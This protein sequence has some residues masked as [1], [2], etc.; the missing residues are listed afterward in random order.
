MCSCSNSV[1]TVTPGTSFS[2]NYLLLIQFGNFLNPPNVNNQPIAITV[3]INSTHY[4]EVNATIS[5]QLYLSNSLTINSFVQSDFSVGTTN[6]TYA[7][8][9]SVGDY[10]PQDPVL[11]ILLPSEIGFGYSSYSCNFFGTAQTSVPYLMNSGSQKVLT[12]YFRSASLTGAANRTALLTVTG[13]VNPMFI[14]NSSTFAII[15]KDV[16]ASN[17]AIVGCTVSELKTSLSA[18]SNTSGD[19]PVY[20]MLMNTTEVNQPALTSVK[21]MLYAPIPMG[22][23]V[24]ILLPPK[25]QP[26]LPVVC[27]PISGYK[28]TDTNPPTCT[29]N[30][31]SNSI[32][33]VNF[34]YQDLVT[35]STA[36]MS[37]GIINPPDS[38]VYRFDFQTLDEIGRIIGSSRRGFNYSAEPGTLTVSALRNDTT[39]DA[40]LKLSFNV[41]FENNLT[42]GSRLQVVI[43][44]EMANITGPASVTCITTGLVS[45]NCTNMPFTGADNT[46]FFN[47]SFTPV[48]S[49][50]CSAGNFIAFSIT[51]LRNPSYIN[52]GAW[53]ININSVSQFFNG[54]IDNNQI[55]INT[56]SLTTANSQVTNVSIG[57]SYVAGT[58]MTL[59]LTFSISLY[60]QTYDGVIV[61]YFPVNASFVSLNTGVLAVSVVN[62]GTTTP[63]TS[64]YQYYDNN[65]MAISSITISG[66]CLK[67]AC[68]S[69]LTVQIQGITF[70]YSTKSY[71]PY[72][73]TIS[74][75]NGAP[76]S[77]GSI[78]Y[79][80]T[81]PTTRPSALTIGCSSNVTGSLSNYNFSFV[82]SI[83]IDSQPNGGWMTISLPTDLDVSSSNGCNVI[84]NV[85]LG[86]SM[87]CTLQNRT[88]TIGYVTGTPQA[89][90]GTMV[91]LLI[92]N[93][94]NP[95]YTMPLA[96]KV[97][98]YFNGAP[99]EVFSGSVSM[100]GLAV[101]ISS[102]AKTNNTY[103]TSSILSI[104]PTF[105]FPVLSSDSVSLHIHQSLFAFTKNFVTLT[106][107]STLAS[108]LASAVVVLNATHQIV[109]FSPL[110]NSSTLNISLQI[111]NPTTTQDLPE[112]W[113]V[114][115]R[116]NFSSQQAT[117]KLLPCDPMVLGGSV[118]SSARVTGDKTNLTIAFSQNVNSVTARI[119]VPANGFDYS[120]ALLP[121][122]SS[123][124]NN[125]VVALTSSPT[126]IVIRN[127][128]NKADVSTVNASVIIY[129]LDINAYPVEVL[130]VSAST[131][132]ANTPKTVSMSGVRSIVDSA[133]PTNL[134]LNITNYNIQT[135]LST[136]RIDLPA[137][138][139]W[140][141]A[142]VTCSFVVANSDPSLQNPCQVTGVAGTSIT[143][144]HPCSASK[145]A[146][147]TFQLV[148]SGTGNLYADSSLTNVTFL[149]NGSASEASTLLVTPPVTTP[150]LTNASIAL[151]SNTITQNNTVSI[152]FSCPLSIPLNSTV[153][154]QFDDL[155]FLA[156]GD[157]KYS[158]GTTNYTGCSNTQGAAGYVLTSR[159]NTL[160]MSSIPANTSIQIQLP[161]TNSYAAYNISQSRVSVVVN[162]SNFTIGVFTQSMRTLLNAD[163]FM[164]TALKNV[165]LGRNTTA[166][167]QSAT[168]SLSLTI[169]VNFYMASILTLMIPKDEVSIPA[170]SNLTVTN[171]TITYSSED[172]SYYYYSLKQN[173]C[174]SN[175]C[176]SRSLSFSIDGLVNNNYPRFQPNA[177]MVGLV[178]NNTLVAP[179]Q[180]LSTT[181]LRASQASITA[182]RS[183]ADSL[184]ITNITINLG[185]IE[186]IGSAVTVLVSTNQSIFYG[187]VSNAWIAGT[188]SNTVVSYINQVNGSYLNNVSIS[189][190]SLQQS[191]ALVLQ[192]TNSALSPISG[193]NF[194][195]SIFNSSLLFYTNSLVP[196]TNEIVPYA[197]NITLT[198]SVSTVASLYSLSIAGS[199]DVADLSGYSLAIGTVEGT[200]GNCVVGSASTS[201]LLNSSSFSLTLTNL[202]N[203]Q[204]TVDYSLSMRIASSNYVFF[205]SPVPILP[206]L[207]PISF[208]SQVSLSN[209][210]VY[211]TVN[212][213]VSLQSVSGSEVNVTFPSTLFTTLSNCYL[214]S[215]RIPNC[216][217]TL[218]NNTYLVRARAIN[219][220]AST[221]STLNFEVQLCPT[222]TTIN[223][224]VPISVRLPYSV[225]TSQ[226]AVTLIPETLPLS[227]SSSSYTINAISTISVSFSVLGLLSTYTEIRLP[228]NIT[229]QYSVPNC[230]HTQVNDTSIRIVVFNTTNLT[231]VVSNVTNPADNRPMTVRINQISNSTGTLVGV[232][233]GSYRMTELGTITV[234]EALRNSS[235]L[236]AP[237][238]VSMAFRFDNTGTVLSITLL[239]AQVYYIG[240]LTCLLGDSEQPCTSQSTQVNITGSWS[241]TRN[242]SIVGF[243]NSKSSQ[244]LTSGDSILVQLYNQDGYQVASNKVQSF[245]IPEEITG[246]LT[247]SN[248]QSTSRTIL[249]ATTLSFAFALQNALTTNNAIIIEQNTSYVLVPHASLN[250][251]VN[252]KAERCSV[253]GN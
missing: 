70:S 64:S 156:N 88:A 6:V 79:P 226:L 224:S 41:S 138:Q 53:P 90:R 67:T 249:T 40:F 206:A 30:S 240:N 200:C 250:C 196:I 130:T 31:T 220:S 76:I 117:V 177:F 160:G 199:F 181:P 111:V 241:D 150:S 145:C 186:N 75:S 142:N 61:I 233:S 25:I 17:C 56:L 58:D 125:T 99:S 162:A 124:A 93:T 77:Q 178:F 201:F 73:F 48:C 204:D 251:F 210:V 231:M 154:I 155:I 110:W 198:R 209:N 29:Y 246:N 151:S 74:T 81:S 192:V 18:S 172:S 87:A 193:S 118:A 253:D 227:I 146:N 42:N 191:T 153:T 84:T 80:A 163:T 229:G 95:Q 49:Q 171:G 104:I 47:I 238:T 83:P 135:N 21:L 234:V 158:I 72:N 65:M 10:V 4:S 121:N 169:P 114:T 190:P 175:I 194:N 123:F 237:V 7:F 2:V 96:Y 147:S 170:T 35:P 89:L 217:A 236:N 33:T 149:I 132:T 180:S 39:V 127:L 12:F 165:S 225:S 116:S 144:V 97:T 112:I 242:V 16:T 38:S 26:V 174:Q 208:D 54:V 51:G 223:A 173:V 235:N 1:C 148:V 143:A 129:C 228:F 222:S 134:T 203:P 107:Q 28:L 202:L 46:T 37:F 185:L 14:G 85:S 100:T 247:V 187:G 105:A 195:I 92:S 136:I 141:G 113:I 23:K 98:S 164:P 15:M 120:S 221:V 244:K 212:I 69:S 167:G 91:S 43:P 131:L 232:N 94:N 139:F 57:G 3:N 11:Q 216:S 50:G 182:S 252:D 13:F 168:V 66:A 140:V 63:I 8:N 82:P 207:T 213:T 71:S 211:R 103:N 78:P 36:F 133:A 45:L 179:T 19:I 5:S 60:F 86:F 189:A 205:S 9:F 59:S 68:G 245:L 34:A 184:V 239:P 219:M 22:G 32:S 176:F 109:T 197:K 214:G 119:S 137:N 243:S 106:Q 157:C 52:P 218:S 122:S 230:S 128:T 152:V 115:K 102:Y 27:S 20:V 248:Y 188:A 126:T 166:C 183:K 55:D 101:G 24:L 159:L 215:T 161:M 44:S 108:G 62:G